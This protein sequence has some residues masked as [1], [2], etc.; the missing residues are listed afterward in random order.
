VNEP[1][2]TGYAPVNGLEI[3]WERRGNGGTPLVVVHGGYGLTSMFGDL[4]DTLAARRTVVAIEL[5]GHGHTR[6]IDRPFTYENFGDDIAGLIDHLGIGPADLLGYSLGGGASLRA[7][8]QHPASIR[9]LALLSAPCRRDVWYPDILDAFDHMDRSGF[10]QF[11]HSPLYAAY[12]EVAPDPDAFPV[13]M[14]KTGELQRRHYNWSD[15]VRDLPMPVL[16]V[17]ADADSI[18]PSHPAEMFTL[19]GGGQRDAGWD[20]SDRP[21]SR[22]AILPGTTHYDVFA[23]PLLPPILADFLDA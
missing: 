18:P 5:Q 6:D 16:L 11:R 17:F 3:Y 21:A 15:E 8:I 14:D 10:E 19:L 12:A 20:G 7:A 1:D 22:L 4:L 9:R 2:A 23:S 13:L